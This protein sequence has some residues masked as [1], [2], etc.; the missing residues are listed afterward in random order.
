MLSSTTMSA[1][2]WK[3]VSSLKLGKIL[4]RWKRTTKRLCWGR[5]FGCHIFRV[6]VNLGFDAEKPKKSNGQSIL[7]VLSE[8]LGF[9]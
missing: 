2:V 1:R 3:R 5:G 6:N 4:P 8:Y 7:Y 9:G